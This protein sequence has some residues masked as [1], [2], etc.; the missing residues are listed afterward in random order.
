MPTWGLEA[1]QGGPPGCPCNN[2]MG[3]SG[4]PYFR[5]PRPA[6]F[7]GT[8]GVVSTHVDG[9]LA[10]D[11]IP[12]RGCGVLRTLNLCLHCFI[13]SLILSL[14]WIWGVLLPSGGAVI[15]KLKFRHRD[16][17]ATQESLLLGGSVDS[18]EVCV[19][20]CVF[21][22]LGRKYRMMTNIISRVCSTQLTAL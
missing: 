16:A 15:W 3:S 13:G 10:P 1:M 19:C 8:S 4:H 9:R 17:Q 22:P 2:S 18:Q 21:K 6:S 12:G 5:L 14:S 20:V 7:Q 11:S